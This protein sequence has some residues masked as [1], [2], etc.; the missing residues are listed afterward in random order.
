MVAWITICI[1]SFYN[2]TLTYHTIASYAR[3]NPCSDRL[4]CWIGKAC[5]QDGKKNSPFGAAHDKC[6]PQRLTFPRYKRISSTCSDALVFAWGVVLA[7]TTNLAA[8][9][10][11]CRPPPSS[12]VWKTYSRSQRWENRRTPNRS[13][14]GNIRPRQLA[15]SG[16]PAWT[17]FYWLPY[18]YGRVFRRT[19][20]KKFCTCPR[21]SSFL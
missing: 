13:A 9:P 12:S 8:G 1:D 18:A 10:R 2:M 6:E 7:G 17:P 16:E 21:L 15:Y 11:R 19:W 20:C 3:R 5:R 4:R 14:L